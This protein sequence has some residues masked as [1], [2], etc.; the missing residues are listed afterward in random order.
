M[1]INKKKLKIC[2]TN[3]E[4]YKL[5]MSDFKYFLYIT[6]DF[7]G[8][9]EPTKV[10]YDIRDFLQDKD[11]RRMI[12]GYRGL[13]KTFITSAYVRW[14]LL[15]K[16]DEN[17]IIVSR[18]SKFSEEI[19][20][21]IKKI[22]NGLPLTKHMDTS[23]SGLNSINKFDIVGK[24]SVNKSP[25]IKCV[26]ISG[27]ITG[28]RR[29]EIIS[30]DVEI[31]SNSRTQSSRDIISEAVK[32]F[33]N[34]I[35]PEVGRIT[36][37]GTPQTE[38]T[39]YKSL[40]SK[41]YKVKIWPRRYP[42]P[43]KLSSYKGCLAN[44]IEED[45][46]NDSSLIWKP[47]NPDQH[48]NEDLEER[49]LDSGKSNFLLQYMLDTELTDAERFP[50]KTSDLIVFNN[51]IEKRPISITWGS[52]KEQRIN[53]LDN[54]G[55]SGDR[56]FSPIFVDDNWTNYSGITM[57]IDP[58][59]RGKDETAY[60]IV[61]MLNG[62]IYILDVGGIQ[63]GYDDHL[64]IKLATLAKDYK[65]NNII[66]ESNF[67]DGMFNKIFQSVLN[68]IHPVELDEIRNYTQKEKRIIDILE[69]LMNRHKL[70]VDKRVIEEDLK[71]ENLDNSLFYQMT[72]I[73]KDKGS[74]KHDDRLDALRIAINYWT[75]YLSINEVE[76][77]KLYKDDLW[78]KEIDRFLDLYS[79][80]N[81]KED[82]WLG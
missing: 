34:I 22:I 28:S 67:G 47:T 19:S 1:N 69:P 6:W 12:Q 48:D 63:G 75:E 42:Q 38:D 56:W 9:P 15:N 33:T 65:V 26:G 76:A 24:S 45:V 32:E 68:S 79:R 66:V 18:T 44:W 59:G 46:L 71:V 43:E 73:T 51:S 37:L 27:Q 10:Q 5:V 57:S 23:L 52:G 36:Y 41:G 25:S 78:E 61:G 30:D 82:N 64:L 81:K 8:L 14:R 35:V 4:L 53:D 80:T 3:E 58:S 31:Q 16:P 13:G 60:A 55:F 50:L 72:R 2:K 39:I 70:I 7:L 62:Y 54:V 17:F 74:L 49:E 20:S 11:K 29:T 21:F 40:I 77:R